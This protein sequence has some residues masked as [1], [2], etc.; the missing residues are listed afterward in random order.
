M[1]TLLVLYR[2]PDG[3]AEA[4]AEFERRYAGE[5]VARGEAYGDAVR[6]VEHRG[7]IRAKADVGGR[8]PCSLDS[9]LHI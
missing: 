6:V 9:A 7:V 4:L 8:G 3:G 5:N 1:T 2:R